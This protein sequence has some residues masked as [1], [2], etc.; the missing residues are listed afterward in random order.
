MSARGRSLNEISLWEKMSLK[1][2]EW[3]RLNS[4]STDLRSDPQPFRNANKFDF[5]LQHPGIRRNHPAPLLLHPPR[6][7]E[8]LHVQVPR[9]PP[10]RDSLLPSNSPPN[11]ARLRPQ[12]RQ[13]DNQLHQPHRRLF[14][15][16]HHLV[17]LLNRRHQNSILQTKIQCLFDLLLENLKFPRAFVDH[18]FELAFFPSFT[19]DNLLH[20]L[21]PDNEK[22]GLVQ[23]SA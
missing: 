20:F 15:D 17:A 3:V 10:K 12:S 19:S 13:Q 23:L 5:L 1:Y 2:K 7:Q 9:L 6:N 16:L 18:H 21:E 4:N 11:L 14:S 8:P 22:F